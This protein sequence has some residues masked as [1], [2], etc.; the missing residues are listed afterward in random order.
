MSFLTFINELTNN[1]VYMALFFLL[2]IVT[3]ING[4]VDAPNAIANCVS[5]RTLYIDHA[6]ILSTICNFIG[7]MVISFIY[8]RVS[9]T[10]YN[11]VNFNENP[12]GYT[13]LV[14]ALIS[15]IIWIALT[16]RFNIPASS[17]HAIIA[18]LL[19]ASFAINSGIGGI[20]AISVLKVIVGIFISLIITFFITR[21]ITIVIISMVKN[22]D[23]RITKRFFDRGQI[24]SGGLLSFAHGLQD[25][26]KIVGI[27]IILISLMGYNPK[28][29]NF[30]PFW[31]QITVAICIGI[32]TA[33]GMKRVIKS[34]NMNVT[35]LDTYEGFISD[36]SSFVVIIFSS[37]A[38]IPISTTQTS[39][40]AVMG[41]GAYKRK[42]K[43][44]WAYAKYL[45]IAWLCTFP[46]CALISYLITK[47]FMLF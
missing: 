1:P 9:F 41:V 5:T 42:S 46:V 10:I 31:I 47:I 15:I 26:Q 23:R 32:G 27:F 16:W 2:I 45:S 4:A 8:S 19:G 22:K 40:S 14:S 13:A 6:L 12:E 39:T 28:T 7:V 38:G 21:I 17:S 3:I 37:I 34:I 44:N 35:N 25:G 36:M 33:I 18:G 24:L 43:V 20:S 11:L 30:L 29:V